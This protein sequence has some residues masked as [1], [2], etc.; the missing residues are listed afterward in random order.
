MYYKVDAYT[1]IY[2]SIIYYFYLKKLFTKLLHD[3]GIYIQ[4]LIFT[5]YIYCRYNHLSKIILTI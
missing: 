5:K 1:F 4:K 2:N 3:E